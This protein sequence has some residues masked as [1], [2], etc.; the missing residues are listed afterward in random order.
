ML[1][2]A[3]HKSLQ[4]AF[5]RTLT[6]FQA[7]VKDWPDFVRSTY[8]EQAMIMPP[9]GPAVEGHEAI[10]AYF[11]VF[12]PFIDHHQ[13]SQELD[14]ASDL[15]YSRDTFTVTITPPGAP[16]IK[17]TGK[18]LTIWRKQADGDWKMLRE[19]WNYDHPA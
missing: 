12:P 4:Q 10:V 13:K 9:N 5:E 1:T 19:I 8:D 3:D 2:D 18:A 11:A 15:L 7:P 16:A 6:K 14:G 17:C